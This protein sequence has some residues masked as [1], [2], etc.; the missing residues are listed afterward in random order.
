[1][2]IN[3]ERTINLKFDEN[4]KAAVLTAIT[5]AQ[6]YGVKIFLI[7]GAVR[8]LILENPV[9]DIDITVEGNAADFANFLRDKYHCEIKSVQENLLT[10]KVQFASGAVI[11]FASTREEK[12]EKPGF[13]PEAFNFGCPLADDVKRRDFTINTLAIHLEDEKNLQLID[14]CGGYNDIL[15]KKIRIL[16]NNSFVDDPSRIIRALKFKQRFNFEIEENT[17]HL[18]Q[19]YLSGVNSQM[20][21]ER[22]KGELRQ[23]FSLKNDNLYSLIINSKAYALI[24]DNPI[25]NFNEN[26][27][28]ELCKFD[29]FN[30]DEIWFI[31]I[32]ALIVN[33]DFAFERLNMTSFEKKVILEVRE[34]LKKNK[35]DNTDDY[36]I[37]NIFNDLQDLSIAIYYAI[38][39]NH[40]VK[41]FLTCLKE[42]KVLISGKDLIELGFIPSP[43]FNELFDLILREKLNGN[44]KTKEEEINYVKQYIKKEE[45]S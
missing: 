29:L 9:K 18:M 21:L 36:E 1:M 38:T 22:I 3:S 35:P 40:A 33:S 41:K 25:M 19:K 39:E 32:A 7:G 11:D 20:P 23:Y 44:L 2:P 17:F 15:N 10:A 16:H 34:L 24:S 30:A 31:Y 8:D 27:I 12:Y 6:E 28:N 43:Y 5:A 13:L 37:Y 4:L 14:Y 26:L 42:I 45:Q